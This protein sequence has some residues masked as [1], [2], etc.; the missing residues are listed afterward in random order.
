MTITNNNNKTQDKINLAF[1]NMACI[2]SSADHG[3]KSRNGSLLFWPLRYVVS[4]SCFRR[5]S[6]IVSIFGPD[7]SFPFPDSFHHTLRPCTVSATDVI[8]KQ[9]KR[10]KNLFKCNTKRTWKHCG[11]S[12][13]VAG[14]IPD[15]VI[16]IFH[17]HNPSGR[18]V[19]LGLT[20]PVTGMC[21]R[22]ISY[23]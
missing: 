16:G 11:A 18:T 21:T 6:I 10:R 13:K 15:D 12:R 4:I 8:V 14:S 19:G 17:W 20:Q 22:N 23:G 3:F 1:D 7:F 5:V 2:S 9:T